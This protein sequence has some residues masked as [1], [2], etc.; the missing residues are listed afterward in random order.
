MW[1]YTSILIGTMEEGCGYTNIDQN[2][3]EEGIGREPGPSDAFG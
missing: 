3:I 2:Q 1:D